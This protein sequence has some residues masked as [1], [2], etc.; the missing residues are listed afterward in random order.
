MSLKID[1]TDIRPKIG[2]KF[3]TKGIALQSIT[4][5][6][7]IEIEELQNEEEELSPPL[8]EYNINVKSI[9]EIQ[10][11]EMN[12]DGASIPSESSTESIKDLQE[13]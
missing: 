10:L 3:G 9:P 2:L 12:K 5:S 6:Q 7:R 1:D 11:A 13:V 4:G 8:M